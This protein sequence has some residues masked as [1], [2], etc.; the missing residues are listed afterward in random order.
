MFPRGWQH[1]LDQPMPSPHANNLA[2]RKFPW[3]FGF[4]GGMAERDKA[5][6]PLFKPGMHL[7]EP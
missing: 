4:H 7:F 6:L 2:G 3:G 5:C 1:I